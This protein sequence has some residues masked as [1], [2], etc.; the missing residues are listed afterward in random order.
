MSKDWISVKDRLPI[1]GWKDDRY[2]APFHEEV[3]EVK[4]SDGRIIKCHFWACWEEK[5]PQSP[6][7]WD[8]DFLMEFDAEGEVTHWR[9]PAE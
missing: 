9:H 4:L 7:Y 5:H 2:Q 3:V 1:T 8:E 6:D